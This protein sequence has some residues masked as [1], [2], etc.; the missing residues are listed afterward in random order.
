MSKLEEQIK[1]YHE[2][3]K[4][5]NNID[6]ASLMINAL[7]SAKS[8]FL[9]VKQKRWAYIISL[10]IPLVGFYFVYKYFNA[11]EEDAMEAALACGILSCF[12][13]F[14]FWLIQISF[15]SSFTPQQIND[16]QNIKPSD[17]YEF[18]Q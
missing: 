3:A 13:L 7:D 14:S 9:P 11:K 12:C 8:N 1:A 2:L 15:R 10:S 17:V 4:T 16:L 6:V 18:T 5:D